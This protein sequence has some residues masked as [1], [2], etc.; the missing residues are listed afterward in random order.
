MEAPQMFLIVNESVPDNQMWVNGKMFDA[1]NDYRCAAENS[2][3]Q[4][5]QPTTAQVS[6]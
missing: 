4:Q 5:L 2:G 6:Q 3:K 1:M